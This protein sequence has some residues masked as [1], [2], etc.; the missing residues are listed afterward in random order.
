MLIRRTVLLS[1]AILTYLQQLRTSQSTQ[2]LQD[3]PDYGAD[4]SISGF[5]LISGLPKS[6]DI[7]PQAAFGAISQIASANAIIAVTLTGVVALQG[8][9]YYS[10]RQIEKEIRKDLQKL[11]DAQNAQSLQ[12][13]AKAASKAS[14]A[15]KTPTKAT[16]LSV[17]ASSPTKLR[18]SPR[19]SRA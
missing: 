4:I 12:S 9:Q 8:A 5:K 17:P 1:A 2:S 3:N 13:P 10:E 15:A 7:L 16:A 11:Q 19:K 6:N 18:R 14:T